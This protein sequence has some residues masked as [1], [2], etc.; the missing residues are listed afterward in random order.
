MDHEGHRERLRQRFRRAGLESFAPHEVLELLLTYAIPR[1]DTK[2]IAYALMDRFG[3]LHAVLQASPDELAQVTGIGENAATLISL[4]M[5]V[6]RAYR[7]SMEEAK[8][9]IRNYSQAVSYC[10]SLFEGERYEKFYVICLGSGMKR[11]NTALISSGDVTEVR[12]YARHVLSVL[13]Q[14]SA[15]GAVISHNHPSGTACPSREDVILTNSIAMLL[16]GVG[17]KLYDHIVVAPSETFSFRRG[18]LLG[19]EGGPVSAAAQNFEQILPAMR[20]EIYLAGRSKKGDCSQ[21]AETGEE[22]YLSC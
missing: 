3:S 13:T 14:C 12:V 4:M 9:E 8:D 6:F 19:M 1:R 17:I 15:L 2:P 5:P 16:D 22:D 18:G 7:R 21:C 11:L 10:E 20:E